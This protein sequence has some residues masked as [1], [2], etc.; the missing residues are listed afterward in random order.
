MKI[1]KLFTYFYTANSLESAKKILARFNNMFP[2]SP[3]SA[4]MSYLSSPGFVQ[5]GFN[6]RQRD[7][8]KPS[9]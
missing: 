3:G 7:M 1:K 4:P 5:A 2:A 8:T 6:V 9:L